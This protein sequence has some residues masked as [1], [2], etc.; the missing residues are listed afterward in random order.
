MRVFKRPLT[1]HQSDAC[2]NA[3]H[4]RCTCRCGGLLHGVDHMEYMEIEKQLMERSN[5]G[6][7]ED[8]VADIIAFL[9][10]EV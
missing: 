1:L 9:K 7:T 3:Q 8:Q 10:G 5:G 2:T 4:P 6:I